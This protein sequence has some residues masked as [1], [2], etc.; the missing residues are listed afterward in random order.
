MSVFEPWAEANFG[1][2]TGSF[3]RIHH[4][5]KEV[6]KQLIYTILTC[7]KMSSVQP[8]LNP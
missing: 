6:M 3:S 7:L 5:L 2:E 4:L 1:I 8:S